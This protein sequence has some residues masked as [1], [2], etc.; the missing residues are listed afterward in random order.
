[1]AADDVPQTTPE[2]MQLIKQTDSRIVYAM[3]GASLESYTRIA[4]LDCYVAFRKDWKRD[5]NRSAS[6]QRRVD[7]KDIE[8]IKNDLAAEFKKVFTK[9]L[10]D[11]GHEIVDHTGPDVLIIRPA[12]VNLDVTAPDLQSAAFTHTVVRSAGEMTL[13]MELFDSMT[14]AIIARV[15]DAQAGDRAG[16]AMEATRMT[17][18]READR[19]L[20]S[21]A[22]E[23][24]GHL[25]EAKAATS[26]A[27]D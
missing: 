25:G 1:M 4:L 19:I 18:K 3:P 22:K 24:E 23:L 7:D 17:N 13:Y 9:E 8:R 12:I 14:S 20:R 16:L 10:T 2:G 15:M 11:A 5:Y 21:W 26:G 6:F 27:T